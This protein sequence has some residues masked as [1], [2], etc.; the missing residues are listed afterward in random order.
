[1]GNVE[2]GQL[3]SGTVLAAAITGLLAIYM[4]WR[5][6]RED[7]RARV[8]NVL[9]DAYAAYASY[10]EFPYVI[11]RRDPSSPASE[12]QRISTEVR[13]TQEKL[14][15][16]EAWTAAEAPTV[17]LAYSALITHMRRIA[18]S[19]MRAAWSRPAVADDGGMNNPVPDY[20]PA[21][22]VPFER[23]YVIATAEH[24]A[25]ISGICG[26]ARVLGMRLRRWWNFDNPSATRKSVE[27]MV[28]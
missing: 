3:F 18:G 27:R 7:E 4:W 24:L 23:A 11:A 25:R 21:E 8:R 13:A 22:L 5:K 16:Y 28:K 10:K 12:R 26:W 14:S 6:N 19:A 20:C 9:A 2:L 17:G 15:Y 1:M